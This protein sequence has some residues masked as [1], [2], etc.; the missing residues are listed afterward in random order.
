MIINI[1]LTRDYRPHTSMTRHRSINII[2][3][4][5]LF[6][7]H[8]SWP[9]SCDKYFNFLHSI[10][11]Y[12]LVFHIEIL[13]C[14]RWFDDTMAEVRGFDQWNFHHKEDNLECKQQSHI[15]QNHLILN[16]EFL[17]YLILFFVN[18]MFYCL[19]I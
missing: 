9:D 15:Q 6:F 10:M 3:T 11:F 13:Q 2:Q 1:L 8:T 5:P 4:S 19:L 17:I 12:Y 18:K 14:F 16:I 7:M